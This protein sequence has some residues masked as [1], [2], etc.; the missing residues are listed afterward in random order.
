MSKAI[1]VFSGGQDSTTCMGW[2]KNRFDE[3]S[4]ISYVYGQRHDIEIRQ[5]RKI[6]EIQHNAANSYNTF[7]SRKIEF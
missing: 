5:A 1:V 3:V 2:A 4:A 7:R 6:A